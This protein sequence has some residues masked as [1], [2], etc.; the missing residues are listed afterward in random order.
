M[1]VKDLIHVLSTLPP[2]APVI[3]QVGFHLSDCPIVRTEGTCEATV[4]VVGEDARARRLRKV[5]E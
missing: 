4:V 3:A 5:E 1:R 2:D